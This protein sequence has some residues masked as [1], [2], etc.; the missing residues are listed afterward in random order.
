MTNVT[1]II[2]ECLGKLLVAMDKG[3]VYAESDHVYYLEELLG[4]V[5]KAI[6]D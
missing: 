1:D 2:F 4:K 6:I 3:E 5:T